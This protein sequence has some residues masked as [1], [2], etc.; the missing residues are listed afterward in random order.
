MSDF[1]YDETNL[2]LNA[3]RQIISVSGFLSIFLPLDWKNEVI[4]GGC[5]ASYI[6]S[7]KINDIDIYILKN[8]KLNSVGANKAYIRDKLSCNLVE[9]K[10][11][12]FQ[13]KRIQYVYSLTSPTWSTWSTPIQLIYTDYDTREEVIKDF[14]YKHCCVSLQN[15]KLYISRKTFDAIVKKKLIVNN[16][17]QVSGWR[18]N[19]FLNRGYTDEVQSESGDKSFGDIIRKYSWSISPTTTFLPG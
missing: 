1:T 16:P 2:L 7:E 11:E 6:Q 17:N 19:K 15:N 10:V 14:D 13:N 12:Y 8:S 3:K 18:R 4:S 5:F 9:S